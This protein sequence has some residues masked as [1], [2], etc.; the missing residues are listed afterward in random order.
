V[1]ALRIPCLLVPDA[2]AAGNGNAR[3]HLLGALQV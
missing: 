1:L 2:I 3:R